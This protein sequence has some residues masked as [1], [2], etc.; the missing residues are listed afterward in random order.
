MCEC[1]CERVCV[2][3]CV[4]VRVC[5]CVCGAHSLLLPRI[6]WDRGG[7]ANRQGISLHVSEEALLHQV[8]LLEPHVAVHL[9]QLI[10]LCGDQQETRGA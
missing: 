5:V 7:W 6:L 8:R 10:D 9:Q 1:E 2:C 4:S 3:V